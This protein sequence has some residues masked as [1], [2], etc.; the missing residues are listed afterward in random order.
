M[1]AAERSRLADLF[2]GSRPI[3]WLSRRASALVAGRL[4]RDGSALWAAEPLRVQEAIDKVERAWGL[5]RDP[6]VAIQL[7]TMYDKAN[8][9]DDALTVLRE[10]HADD[11][12]H[13]LVRHHAAITLLR[14][15]RPDDVRAF[16]DSVLEVDPD[17]AFA[18]FIVRLLDG[19]DGWVDRI[20]A[21]IEGR[22]SARRPF[23]LALP[24]WGEAHGSYFL[25]Y[26]CATLLS[27]GNLPAMAAGHDVHVVLFTT[28]E[29]EKSLHADPLF[30]RLLQ[31]ATVDVVH[32]GRELVDYPALMEACYGQQPVFYSQESLAFY[33][34]RNCKFALM[35]CA[36][37]AALAA[38][39]RTD[40]LVSCLIADAVLSDGALPRMAGLMATAD[41]VLV[42]AVQM[43]GTS[44]RPLLEE[45]F[46]QPDGTLCLTS[47]SCERLYVEHI[48]AGNF[49]D[50]ERRLDPPLRVAWRVGEQGLL[51]HGN[52]YHPFCLRPASFDHPLRLTIDPVDS[53]FLDR[54]S[55]QASRIHLVTDASIACF[56]ID[57]DPILEPPGAASS[58]SV[59][60]ASLWLWGYWGRLRG[61]LF[62]SPIR[63]GDAPPEAWRQ[64]ETEAAALIGDIVEGAS[65]MEAGRPRRSSWS[66]SSRWLCEA[67]RSGK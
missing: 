5:G 13:A 39:R 30:D 64:A 3:D 6:A 22:R 26:L 11:P 28:E 27:P 66:L 56:S 50:A 20:A 31:H 58:L 19:Y 60:M 4:L 17:D 35:S 49:A 62:R 24:V 18:R 42:H 48:P 52:H 29:V 47:E 21:A 43:P 12:R 9:H 67:R 7:A 16:F 59:P 57:D 14:H 44:V 8:R 23:V 54:T 40:A 51:V 15:G 10:A 32:Y 41:A 37:Y 34:A 55:L 38:G 61:W 65:A 36:H 1:S 2:P 45:R 25:R 33:Y 46:R 63:F 53:R